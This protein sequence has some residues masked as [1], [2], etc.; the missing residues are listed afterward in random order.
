MHSSADVGRMYP[1]FDRGG[2]GTFTGEL[3]E[4]A[5]VGF[6]GCHQRIGVG[7]LRSKRAT[8]FGKPDRHFSLGVCATRYGMHLVE[9]QRRLMRHERPNRSEDR[10]HRTVAS[11]LRGDVLTIDIECQGRGLRTHR[12]GDHRQRQ[13]LDPI[14]SVRD[15]LVD[16]RFDVFVVDLLL[17][18]SL[19]FE[20]D[21]SILELIARE[22]VT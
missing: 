16:Q 7:S 4:G 19:C 8:T 12:A 3:V 2:L 9:L 5:Q 14:V 15:F 6:C 22:F 13:H 1:P 18:V 21:E 11:R 17:A 20:A 10:V